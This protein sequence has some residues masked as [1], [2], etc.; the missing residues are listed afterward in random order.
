MVELKLKNELQKNAK[1]QYMPN[2]SI[3]LT[4]FRYPVFMPD[5]WEVSD[6]GTAR[7][8]YGEYCTDRPRN[9]NIRRA[10]NSVFEIAAANEWE[11]MV[12]F[13]LDSNVIDRYDIS[14]ISK[15]FLKWLQNTSARRGLRY[16]IIPE[17]HADGAIHFHGLTAGG[18]DLIDSGTV[19]VSGK[20]KPIK[21]S[22]AKRLHIPTEEW[23]T[24]WNVQNYRFGYSSAIA[25]DGN[26]EAVARYVTK[27]VTKDFQKIFGKT[28]FAGGTG[29]RRRLPF[30]LL[31]LDFDEVC[32]REYTAPYIGAVK[33]AR[34][35]AQ[36]L[37]ALK[38]KSQN[39]DSAQVGAAEPLLDWEP[40]EKE[41]K[42]A[43]AAVC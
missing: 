11:Y 39:M 43:V 3:N 10:K 38:A 30:E 35:S 41:E 32:G 33:Y 12:T 26:A 6:F 13:T 5:G 31:N 28:Y 2:G 7:Q 23:R 34:V 40:K 22:T 14:A 15:P 16:L 8:S 25:L 1:I 4:C 9:D 37:E 18:L 21:I 19:K 36:E 29:L 42:E 27:Y 24:V 20:K 17:R